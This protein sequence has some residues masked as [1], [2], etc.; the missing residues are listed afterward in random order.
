LII[1]DTNVLSEPMRQEPSPRVMQ[2]LGAQ[3]PGDL[4]TTSITVAEVL[5]GIRLL[6]PGRR[7]LAL[8]AQ[9]EALFARE[10]AGRVLPFGLEAARAYA[11]LTADRRR[12]GRPISGFDA[13]IGA[14]ARSAGATL[15]TRN[16]I[17]FQGCG[18]RVVNPWAD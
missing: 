18:I 14:I 12:A 13:Q 3:P 5:H 7:R 16:A 17:D 10:L 15:A 2:W 4:F 9:A 6:A 8:E 1:L 11:A